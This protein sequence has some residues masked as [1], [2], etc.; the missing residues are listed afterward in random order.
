MS[1]LSSPPANNDSGH[2][3]SS[4]THTVAV[5]EHLVS[6]KESFVEEEWGLHWFPW[7][8]KWLSAG[9]CFL[10]GTFCA[11]AF[12]WQNKVIVARCGDPEDPDCSPKPFVGAFWQTWL[13]F[14]G[15]SLCIIVWLM[16][17]RRNKKLHKV[18]YFDFTVS[19]KSFAKKEAKWWW[20]ILPSFLDNFGTLFCNIGYT[21]TYASTVQML[22]NFL[23][24]VAAMMQLGLIRRALRVHEWIG[25]VLITGAMV[26]TAV[27][28]VLNPEDTE[29]DDDSKAWLGILMAILGT[30]CQGVQFVFEEWVYKRRRYSPVK[31]VGVEG[32]VG[33]VAVS[34]MM[35]IAQVTGFEDVRAS[36]YQ[37]WHSTKIGII[38]LFYFFSCMLFNGSAQAT[39]KLGSALLRSIMFALRGPAVWILDLCNRWIE[40]D[41]Y[42]LGGIFIFLIGFAIYVR[43]YPPNKFP[44]MH[45]FFSTPWHWCC[46]KP[47]LDED[48]EEK[49]EAA[50]IAEQQAKGEWTPATAVDAP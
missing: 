6:G 20:W 31:T 29:L 44:R 10:A 3:H 22:R 41:Y 18:N 35:P 46:T 1:E 39:T 34:I 9:I 21:L 33:I 11:Y 14:F 16:D 38:T 5:S 48:Y 43:C 36:L 32:L 12:K 19:N 28:A 8:T 15:E 42:N 27:P 23:V 4:S 2:K 37:Y 40:F 45:K 24:V 30:A 49:L 50:A 25:V 47:E 13:M 26:L 17:N 7:W